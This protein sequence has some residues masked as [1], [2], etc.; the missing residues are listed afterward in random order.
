MFLP[1]EVWVRE[2]VNSSEAG[3]GAVGYVLLQQVR[4]NRSLITQPTSEKSPANRKD[5]ASM[6]A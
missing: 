1:L 5:L 2:T 4:R 3:S 6:F